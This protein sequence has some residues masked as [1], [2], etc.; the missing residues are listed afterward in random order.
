VKLPKEWSVYIARCVDGSLYTGI[1][2]D[3]RARLAA[4][5]A[6]R[7]AAYTRS[8][9]PVKL[10]YREEGFTRSTALSREA[11]IKSLERP[12]KLALL[13]AARAARR[14]LAAAALLLAGA[15]L[16]RA[17]PT[18]DKE[19]PVAVSSAAPQAFTFSA[20]AAAFTYPMRMYF[21]RRSTSVQTRVDSASSADGLARA[22]DA[23][24]GHLSTSTL[25]SVSASSITGCGV[26]PLTG[27]GFRML[28]SIVSTTGA[29]RIHSSTSLDGLH[30]ANDTGTVVDNNLT[31]LA[32]PKIVLLNDASWRLYYVGNTNAGGTDL[33]HRQ[34]FSA[35][36]V[37]QGANWSAP[38]LVLST[39]AF[40]VGAGVL[41][42]GKVR[43]YFTDPLPG[44][45]T[46]TVV[47]SAL[48]TDANGTSF[49]VES[50]FRVSTASASG[51]LS[52]PVP[53]RSTDTF[54]WRLYYDFADPGTVS[55]ADVHTAMT[56]AP[57]PA[58]IL[59]NRVFNSQTAAAL[60]ING[61]V[62]S[63]AP[64]AAPTITLSL[65]GQT[66][67]PSSALVRT[68][69]QTLTQSFNILNQAS[70]FWN[71]TVVNADGRTTI[72]PGA[73]F[74]DFPS[75]SV[76][77]VNN[78]L[79]PR[80]GTSTAVTITTF[81]DGHTTARLF[82]L[83]GRSV[84]TLFDGQQAKGVL[85]LAWDGRDGAGAPVASGLY[86]LHVTGAKIDTKAKIVVIR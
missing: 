22:E 78:L 71:L 55:T 53:A 15:S 63:G 79:R 76:G 34:I 83:D 27:G 40:E 56:G 50:G 1:A 24:N 47:L 19:D 9:R 18:F 70:G 37:N 74:V 39:M 72:L 68:D 59:P 46:A 30:W 20:P 66:L 86:L 36:S 3:V 25:P 6:G 17:V 42:D 62:F 52:F 80:T 75:G 28:Y 49:A 23:Y 65:G 8:R 45:T 11:S 84:R 29:F 85:N 4:H 7:G 64:A 73:L 60:T 13:K 41:T 31:Y 35:R 77:L 61:D 26:L 57:A 12:G 16:A 48:S 21:I 67:V 58:A 51:S 44:S 14:A 38:S 33:G 54:R 43:L 82:T 69:D 32:D 2:K 81:N 10:V 5:N